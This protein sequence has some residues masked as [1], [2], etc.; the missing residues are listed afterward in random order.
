MRGWSAAALTA[1]WV[2]WR[3]PE[4]QPCQGGRVEQPAAVHLTGLQPHDEVAVS[5][6]H[7]RV[8]GLAGLVVLAGSVLR[9]PDHPDGFDVVLSI[10]QLG[11]FVPV[12]VVNTVRRPAFSLEDSGVELRRVLTT[13]PLITW[14]RV[15]E[16]QVQGRWQERSTLVHRDG[17][18]LPLA[19]MPPEDARRLA[20][21]VRAAQRDEASPWA[22][23][24]DHVTPRSAAE[25]R[26]RPSSRV[27][28]ALILLVARGTRPSREIDSTSCRART[29]EP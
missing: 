13:G 6:A 17:R 14:R 28:R 10:V 1:A 29:A 26:R 20:D 5:R 3:R 7:L 4:L 15:R 23:G 27:G 2:A 11:C 21:A 12:V 8:F 22:P 24:S 25:S 18:L 16:V 19:G 9:L